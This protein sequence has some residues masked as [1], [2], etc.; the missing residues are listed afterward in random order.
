MSDGTSATIFGE[1]FGW[2]EDNQP[3][4]TDLIKY[5]LTACQQ[6]D[7]SLCDCEVDE[8]LV[9]KDLVRIFWNKKWGDWSAVYKGEKGFDK[10]LPW[11]E[12]YYDKEPPKKGG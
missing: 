3:D 7:F 6:Y 9:K 12:D 1:L 10:A 11:E 5:L 8:F 2:I 4:N